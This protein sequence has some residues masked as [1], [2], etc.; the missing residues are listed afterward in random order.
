LAGRSIITSKKQAQKPNPAP[1]CEDD[2]VVKQIE[3]YKC[4]SCGKTYKII[5]NFP[6]S[7]STIF[8]GWDYHMPFCKKCVNALYDRYYNIYQNESLAVRRVCE[9]F[10]IYFSEDIVNST[11]VS[12]KNQTRMIKYITAINM[13]NYRGKTYDDTI[14]EESKLVSSE[15]DLMKFK[16]NGDTTINPNAIERWGVGMFE[17]SEYELLEDHY[18][19]LKKANPNCDSNQEIFIKSLCHLNLL[20]VKALKDKNT[21]SYIDANS[22]YAKTFKQAGLKTIQETDKNADDCWG[23][24][25]EQISQYTPEEY[26]KDKKL[27]ADFDGIGEQFSRFVLRPLKNLLTKDNE[28]DPEY[29]V[30]DTGNE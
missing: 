5:D 20:Q 21:K 8:V 23:I 18:K 30:E 27:Y 1:I 6:V 16:E 19:M 10:D 11:T 17:T 9:R 22:E 29:N 26:Y 3:Y 14:R 7:Q 15:E 28:R 25:M 2:D 12:F 4:S 13:P 24:F